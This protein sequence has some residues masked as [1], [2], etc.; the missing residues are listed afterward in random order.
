[1]SKKIWLQTTFQTHLH[2]QTEMKKS[3]KLSR[4][5]CFTNFL[6]WKHLQNKMQFIQN[7]F[8]MSKKLAVHTGCTCSVM[9]S[10]KPQTGWQPNACGK[11]CRME[12]RYSRQ[13]PTCWIRRIAFQCRGQT[14]DAHRMLAWSTAAE[15]RNER[16][17]WAFSKL[18]RKK[19]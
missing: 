12:G 14:G 10:N 11:R 2:R 4:Y 15:Q 5:I 6:R 7:N 3:W 8:I 13:Q 1:M 9:T 17:G 16:T 19:I 18:D